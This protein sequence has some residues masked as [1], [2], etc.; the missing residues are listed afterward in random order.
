MGKSAREYLLHGAPDGPLKCVCGARYYTM[1]EIIL[2]S[3]MV[4]QPEDYDTDEPLPHGLDHNDPQ[5]QAI[6]LAQKGA[7]NERPN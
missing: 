2:H 6:Y 4:T 1:E 3:V 7:Q 5:S